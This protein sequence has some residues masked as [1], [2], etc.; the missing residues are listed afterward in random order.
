MPRLARG[1]FAARHDARVTNPTRD[2]LGGAVAAELLLALT[3]D[4]AL[5]VR[6]IL[7]YPSGI[8]FVVL[9]RLREPHPALFDI[10][11]H[12]FSLVPRRGDRWIHLE[13]EFADGSTAAVP[14]DGSRGHALD[15]EGLGGG[16]EGN[17]RYDGEF[18]LPA[19]PPEGPVTFRCRWPYKGIADAS[20]GVDAALIHEAASRSRR[21]WGEPD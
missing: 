10:V 12:S 7:A 15:L 14:R 11:T 20:A 6:H 16:G 17:D 21:L 8:S 19:L 4:V 1:P 5:I 9:I 2:F 13:V 18:W 3:D